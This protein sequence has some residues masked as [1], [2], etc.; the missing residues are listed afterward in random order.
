MACRC[1]HSCS[2]GDPE[3]SVGKRS[4]LPNVIYVVSLCL[5]TSE[6]AL[7]AITA[8]TPQQTSANE[9]VVTVFIRD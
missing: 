1:V 4:F 8:L 3:N 7:T 6:D 9:G 2:A 5:G